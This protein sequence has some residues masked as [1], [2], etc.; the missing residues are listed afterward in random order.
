MKI[1]LFLLAN[2]SFIL[3]VA[4]GIFSWPFY[5]IIFI[6]LAL[7]FLSRKWW[8]FILFIIG[9]LWASWFLNYRHSNFN[10]LKNLSGEKLSFAAQVCA[11]P[12]NRLDSQKII[13]CSPYGKVLVNLKLYPEYHL[14]DNLYFSGKIIQ[15]EEFSGF[16]YPEYLLGKKIYF[17]SYYPYLE[18]R[19]YK[20]SFYRS[21]IN[22]KEKYQTIINLGLPEPEA[23]LGGALILGY[24]STL[25]D[26]LVAA[27]S[28][29]GLSHVIAVSGTHITFLA[30]CLYKLLNLLPWGK[31]KNFWLLGIFLFSY[32]L[33][34]GF[35][36]AA[37]RSLI[38]GLLCFWQEAYGRE[39]DFSGAFFFSASLMLI[40][41]PWLLKSDLGFQLS[42]AAIASL[43][44]LDPLFEKIKCRLWK[45]F[46]KAILETFRASLAAQIFV[47]PLG[48]LAFHKAS[49]I[50]PISNLFFFWIFY[51]MIILIFLAMI[52]S[53]L[54]V[55]LS[56]VLFYIPFIF[57]RL[58]W[59]GSL[60]LANLPLATISNINISPSF[61]YFYY[62]VL[63]LII[64]FFHKRS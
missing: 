38:M 21:L 53:F 40:F 36:A 11:E 2:I 41:N 3:G 60:F 59:Q 16:D 35:Q 45:K 47:W 4:W 30:F 39:R 48:A 49:I 43:L 34:S 9:A 50:S 10:S 56:P 1:R 64:W 44:Y 29:A 32:T 31:K 26:D 14:G 7:F 28:G 13:L 42:F 18:L 55:S 19:S 33:L 12:D 61:L 22:L 15:A 27:F 17:V 20:N 6:W 63:L 52:L 46:P 51:P 8:V 37:V 62:A 25:P 24:K 5:A 23:G 54:F 57:L 58:F